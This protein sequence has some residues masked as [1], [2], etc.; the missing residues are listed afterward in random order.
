L[1]LL[2]HPDTP[3]MCSVCDAFEARMAAG[4]LAVLGAVAQLVERRHGMAEARDSISLSSTQFLPALLETWDAIGFT[5]GGLVAAEGSFIITT[6]QRPFADG[7]PRKHFVFQVAMAD[8]DRPLLEALRTFLGFGSIHDVPKRRSHWEPESVLTVASRK[9]HHAATIP[10][11]ECYLLPCAKRGQFDRWHAALIAFE[12]E[13][14]TRYGKG[15]SRCSVPR[16][17]KPVRGRGLCR[18]H[19][20]R[21]TGY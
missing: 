12:N 10:F 18:S 5:L 3:H 2:P 7:T 1:S 15:R 13:R 14:P 20:Y 17:G 11:A 21:A 4:N 9:A 16:C 8:R 19:Y 6:K